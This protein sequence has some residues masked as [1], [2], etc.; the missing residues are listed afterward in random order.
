MTVNI[1]S[2]AE[3]DLVEG[4]EFYERQSPGLGAYFINSLIDD[5]DA[6]ALNGGIHLMGHRPPWPLP[7][8]G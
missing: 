7:K 2:D 3:T 6:L 8:V 1:T 5:I 4:Y